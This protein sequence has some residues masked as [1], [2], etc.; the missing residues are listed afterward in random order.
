MGGRWAHVL[1]L[2]LWLFLCAS[3]LG[4]GY[5]V[6]LAYE[7]DGLWYVAMFKN[8]ATGGWGTQWYPRLGAPFGAYGWD[9]PNADFGFH[10]I[11]WLMS[12]FSSDAGLLFNAFFLLTF[13]SAYIAAYWVM[14]RL[15]TGVALAAAGAFAFA[16]LPYHFWRIWHLWLATYFV[17]PLIVWECAKLW[18]FEAASL[19]DWLRTNKASP[20]VAALAGV[21]GAYYAFFSVLLV[22]VTGLVVALRTRSRRPLV[23]ALALG[24]ITTTLVLVQVAPSVAYRAKFGGNPEVAAR[25]AAHSQV[26]GL[27]LGFA[28]TP[29]DTYRIELGNRLAQGVRLTTPMINENTVA[30]LG[31][32]GVLGTLLLVLV[33]L[34][35]PF[36]VARPAALVVLACVSLATILWATVG[37]FGYLFALLV[38]PEIRAL[39]RMSIVLGFTG[40]A[41]FVLVADAMLLR[42]P[43]R[44]RTVAAGALAAGIMLLALVDEIPGMFPRDRDFNLAQYPQDRE[45]FAR[46]EASVPPGTQVLSLPYLEFPERPPV[47]RETS[48]AHLRPLAHT[49]TLKWSY[50]AIRE[51]SHDRWI[52]ALSILAPAQMLQAARASGFGGIYLE[53]RALPDGGAELRRAVS[54]ELGGR[55]WM[56]SGSGEQFFIAF[57]PRGDTPVELDVPP[58]LSI[59]FYGWEGSGPNRV[60]WCRDRGV[61][62]ILNLERRERTVDIRFELQALSA[63]DVTVSF[64]GAPAQT[65][66]VEPGRLTPVA[67]RSVTL[68]PGEN[69]LRVASDGPSQVPGNGDPRA[70]SFAV[71]GVTLGKGS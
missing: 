41:A 30:Y 67:L 52:R 62:Q 3:W 9:F 28:L 48:Y 22:G 35:A 57:E 7:G 69:A 17:I 71:R 10:A 13:P 49:T 19:R 66:R 32:V 12:R 40:I 58:S 29:H 37:G 47:H 24:A 1:A 39:N 21:M 23:A 56:A 11:A 64:N 5:D 4:R 68:Q 55:A 15:G 46:V 2:A 38:T 43:E 51:R 8:F 16:L 20:A 70:L 44:R 31:I 63:R 54:A 42:W 65:H 33:S 61:M 53:G 26:L 34:G 59:G 60:T 25:G 27:N 6:P 18:S 45:F 50:A 14:R 36:P